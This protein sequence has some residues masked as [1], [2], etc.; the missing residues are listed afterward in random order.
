MALARQSYGVT[1][2]TDEVVAQQQAI[3]DTFH[4]LELIP[5]AISIADAVADLGA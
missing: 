3:A 5:S 2:L 1:P 4:E